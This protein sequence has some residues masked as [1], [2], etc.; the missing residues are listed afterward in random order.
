MKT[1]SEAVYSE[2]PALSIS[3]VV[4]DIFEQELNQVVGEKF[5]EVLEE[6][7]FVLE[8]KKMKEEDDDDDDKDLY[9]EEN[10]E[11]DKKDKNDKD[12]E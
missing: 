6:N 12:K 1:L 9:A 2:T 10:D 4:E 5:S 8:K 3:E 7:G 11:K